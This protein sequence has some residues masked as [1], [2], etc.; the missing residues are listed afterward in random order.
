MSIFI[1]KCYLIIMLNGLTFLGN[2]K[3]KVLT[4]ECE[5]VECEG[6]SVSFSFTL[7]LFIPFLSSPSCFGFTDSLDHE[8]K[9]RLLL[10]IPSRVDLSSSNGYLLL[11]FQSEVCFVV[12]DGS[13]L[14]ICPK[15]R[16]SR[17]QLCS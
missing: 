5:A 6:S 3:L 16:Q 4:H 14:F 2:H 7:F 17:L 9:W 15:T 1:H 13:T 8:K 12:Y 11:F 10:S